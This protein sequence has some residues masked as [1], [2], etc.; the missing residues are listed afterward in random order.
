MTAP[1]EPWKGSPCIEL[2]WHRDTVLAVAVQG[3][4]ACP[5]SSVEGL[6]TTGYRSGPESG[7]ILNVEV[8][9]GDDVQ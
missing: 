8:V 6:F 1:G 9:V 4:A 3:P 2:P 5:W 7:R